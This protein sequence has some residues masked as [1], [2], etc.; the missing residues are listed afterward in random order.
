MSEV[1]ARKLRDWSN[2]YLLFLYVDAGRTRCFGLSVHAPAWSVKYSRVPTHSPVFHVGYEQIM[3]ITGMI[4][5]R[6]ISCA[7]PWITVSEDS[8]VRTFPAEP[9]RRYQGHHILLPPRVGVP[10][11]STGRLRCFSGNLRLAAL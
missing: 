1:L 10:R 2:R 4:L 9:A 6:H 8:S 3:H 5:R 7:A 11:Q